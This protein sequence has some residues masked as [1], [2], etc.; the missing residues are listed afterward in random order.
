MFSSYIN[1]TVIWSEIMKR[2]RI[3]YVCVCLGDWVG[4]FYQ[5]LLLRKYRLSGDGKEYKEWPLELYGKS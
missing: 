2:R 3:E 5:D 4:G 1:D